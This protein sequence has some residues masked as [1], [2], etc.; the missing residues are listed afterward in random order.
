MIGRR[1]LAVAVVALCGLG[2]GNR[3]VV[4]TAQG[5]S[6]GPPTPAGDSSSAG[7][8]GSALGESE[9]GNAVQLED[10]LVEPPQG[11]EVKLDGS[12]VALVRAYRAGGQAAASALVRTEGFEMTQE[13]LNVGVTVGDEAEMATIRERIEELGGEVTVGFANQ[14]YALLPISAVEA[15]ATE[16]SVWSM[17]V[18]RRVTSPLPQK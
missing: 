8:A 6:S 3:T 15:L 5:G 17:A 14:I 2:C 1:W 10:P 4:G 12:L 11:V 13:R 9:L 7:G 18:P 16:E